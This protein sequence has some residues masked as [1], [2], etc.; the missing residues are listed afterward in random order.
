M[1]VQALRAAFFFCYGQSTHVDIPIMSWGRGNNFAINDVTK[2]ARNIQHRL[3]VWIVPRGWTTLYIYI[4]I[5]TYIY[6][7]IRSFIYLFIYLS[8][9]VY[10][11]IYIHIFNKWPDHTYIKC[12]YIRMSPRCGRP[13]GKLPVSATQCDPR[14]EDTS[15]SLEPYWAIFGGEASRNWD[16]FTMIY[17]LVT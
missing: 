5:H 12:I 16:V 2:N 3:G 1:L 4:N 8:T 7:F 13:N 17:P 14:C 6:S 9:G 11:L 10:N 15:R